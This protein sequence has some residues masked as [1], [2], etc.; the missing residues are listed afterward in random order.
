MRANRRREG[1]GIERLSQ[2]LLQEDLMRLIANRLALSGLLV[3]FVLSTAP[4]AFAAADAKK[5]ADGLVAAVTAT[6]KSQ[7]SYQGATASGDDVTITG[8]KM[9]NQ[10]GET[11][12]IPT[13]VITGVG[14]RDKGGFTAKSMSFDGG[15]ATADGNTIVWQT[16]AVADATVPTPDE[17]KAK[18]HVKPFT[19]LDVTGLNVTGPDLAAPVAIATVGMTIDATDDGTPRDFTMKIGGIKVPA[20]IFDKHPQQKAVLDALGYGDLNSSFDV[21]AGYDTAKDTLTLRSLTLSTDG[22]ATLGIQARISGI[23]LG[24]ALTDGGSSVESE[25]N[26]KL[27]SLEIRFDNAGVVERALDMQAKMMGASRE[28]V[29]NQLSGALP[30]MLNMIGNQGFQDKVATAAIAFLKSPKSITVVAAP[31]NPVSFKAISDAAINAPQT[32]PDILVVDITANK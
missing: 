10:K 25:S 18:A 19:K 27:E 13:L 11:V 5:V 1:I 21:E 31:T 29:V 2:L 32:L 14:A 3:G 30:F 16:G 15:S 20:A 24:K 22:V 8:Y 28:D 4:S 23:S 7:A 12:T 6:G 26:G 9:T 17:I